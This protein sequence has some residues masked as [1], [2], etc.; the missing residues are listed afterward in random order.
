MSLKDVDWQLILPLIVVQ[1]ALMIIALIDLVRRES[2]AVRGPKLMWVFIIVLGS[3]LGPV[4][5]FTVGR[6]SDY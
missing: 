1:A 5:Y 6:K 2:K 4:V 3:L